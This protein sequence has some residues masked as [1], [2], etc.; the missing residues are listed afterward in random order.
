MPIIDNN[1]FFS[2]LNIVVNMAFF[3]SFILVAFKT[4]IKRRVSELVALL[5]IVLIS[6]IVMSCMVFSFEAKYTSYSSVA[7]IVWMIIAIAILSFIVKDSLAQIMFVIFVAVN[8][9]NNI[10]SLALISFKLLPLS[11]PDAYG[12]F[13][14]NCVLLILFV[15]FN[16]FLMLRLY[17]NIVNSDIPASKFL[18][19]IPVMLYMIFLL[20]FIGDYWNKPQDFTS[21]DI[22]SMLLWTAATYVIFCIIISVIIQIHKSTRMEEQAILLEKQV[23]MQQEQYHRLS[24][25]IKV[26]AKIRHDFRQHLLTIMGFADNENMI[27]LKE[28]LGHYS[29]S[30]Y[31]CDN[32]PV[33]QNVAVDIILQHYMAGADE[34]GINIDVKADVPE[35]LPV[36]DMDLCVIF[37]NL[38]ENAVEA[39]ERQ[40]E[41]HRFISLYTKPNGNQLLIEIKNSFKSVNQKDGQ[42][43]S[44]K[45]EGSGI[46][47]KSVEEIVMRNEGVFKIDTEDNVFRVSI[48]INF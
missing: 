23:Q 35:K 2:V 3:S 46:G 27:A 25:N 42:F 15:P 12:V 18:W 20:K 41:G 26:T 28:Y 4:R 45:R 48:L 22:I 47:L 19:T 16:W 43:F 30:H 24:Q 13:V 7:I 36:R 5:S 39:C 37:G 6:S 14:I 11:W 9:Y 31:T 29:K 10:A 1:M 21:N 38:F 34:A 32:V 40:T 44:S 33:C 8:M 17:R